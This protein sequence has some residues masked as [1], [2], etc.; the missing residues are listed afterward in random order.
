MAGQGKNTGKPQQMAYLGRLKI[1]IV[2]HDFF[3]EGKTE[4]PVFPLISGRE[5][6]GK[7]QAFPIPFL[8]GDGG[9]FHEDVLA[10]REFLNFIRGAPNLKKF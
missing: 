7:L 4:N 10:I 9:L 8:P 1:R 6:F 3:L 5:F 2:E